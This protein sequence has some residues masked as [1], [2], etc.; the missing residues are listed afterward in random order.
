MDN[1]K[2][3]TE[4]SFNEIRSLINRED[5]LNIEGFVNDNIA[6]VKGHPFE[7]YSFM[8][9]RNAF[10]L[11]DMR[12]VLI[13]QG[14][15]HPMINLQQYDIK[16]NDMI[17][18]GI[19]NVT[20]LKDASQNLKVRGIACSEEILSS[21]FSYRIPTILKRPR[22]VFVLHLNSEER[23][24]F[25][26]LHELIFLSM[27]SGNITLHVLYGLI[28]TL[29]CY[30]DSLY[31][32]QQVASGHDDYSHYELLFDT[33]ISL[34]TQFGDKRHTV[35]FY[36]D[37]MSMSERH[38]GK[39]VKQISG[40]SA[41]DWI[42][43]NTLNLSKIYLRYTSKCIKEISDNLGFSNQSN[44]H[45]YFKDATGTTPLEFRKEKNEN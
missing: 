42:D 1:K 27:N 22:L 23:K 13:E 15:T 17:F 36:S 38:L 19:N 20:Q 16:E 31:K 3:I 40:I 43:R 2:Q 35:T 39:V 30:I 10:T 45:R 5:N 33:F 6:V 32:K 25:E 14:E 11:K 34:L 29:I 18:T 21:A 26:Q 8:G 9:E 44:F 24:F 7:M 41:K 12:C 37:M 4:I 28:N